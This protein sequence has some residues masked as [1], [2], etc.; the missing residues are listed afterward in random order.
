[1]YKENQKQKKRNDIPDA[2]K[3]Q[4][5][6]KLENSYH[7]LLKALKMNQWIREGGTYMLAK[8]K[9]AGILT[10]GLLAGDA[11]GSDKEAQE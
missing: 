9:N 1:M 10:Q 4:H 3:Q 2:E 8:A 6:A 5:E 7:E 11:Y